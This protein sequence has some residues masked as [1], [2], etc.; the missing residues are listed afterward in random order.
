MIIL[1]DSGVLGALSNPNESEINA[2]LEQWLFNKIKWGSLI[3]SQVCKYEVKRSLLKIQSKGINK[4]ADLEELIDFIPI[5]DRDIEIA[6]ELW[7]K[8]ITEGIQVAPE[9]DINF[10]I[11]LCAQWQR[12]QEE[13]P[14]RKVIIATTNLRHLRRFAEAELWEN[15]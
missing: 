12:L 14:G 15:L 1:L 8:S 13:N 9:R 2:R 11:I 6:C 3:T 7:V 10:D 5:V 4:L